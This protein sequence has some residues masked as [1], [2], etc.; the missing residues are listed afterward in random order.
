MNAA[1]RFIVALYW[2]DLA[3]GGPEEGGWWYDTGELARP[4]RVCA[5]EAAAAALAAR[6]NRLL[7]RL[8][9]HRRPVHSVAYDGD[10]CAALVFEA[11]APPRFPDARPHN[12]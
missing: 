2:V 10:R 5:T 3:Y 7:A 1:T 11:T 12:E 8:Q 9:R 6:V 4:L